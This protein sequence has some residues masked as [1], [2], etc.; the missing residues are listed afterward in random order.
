[1]TLSYIP[2]REFK[3]DPPITLA[4][5]NPSPSI[6]L[7]DHN[8][9]RI[10]VKDIKGFEIIVLLFASVFIDVLKNEGQGLVSV[11]V[12]KETQR[13]QK[14]EDKAEERARRHRVEEIDRETERLKKIAHEE[15]MAKK[16][17]DEEIQRET[18]RL[19]W[20][21]GFYGDQKPP[22]PQRPPSRPVSRP[23]KKK[24][25]WNSSS[26]EWSQRDKR[27]NGYQGSDMGGNIPRWGLA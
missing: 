27:W 3:D 21:E 25:W 22:L 5:F 11:D 13:L 15:F 10:P 12:K 23:G 7:L 6:T 19:R 18:E 1:M 14:I 4:L 20:Q 9:P 8:F 2:P 16:R 17:R 24:H 26:G